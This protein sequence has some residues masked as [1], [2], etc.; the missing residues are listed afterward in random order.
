[1]SQK[2][3]GKKVKRIVTVASVIVVGAFIA[4][5]FFINGGRQNT[6]AMSQTKRAEG[7]RPV[8]GFFLN[9]S[10]YAERKPL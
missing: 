4:T 10:M 3:K 7:K 1:M 9:R 6:M 5:V 2:V 8:S